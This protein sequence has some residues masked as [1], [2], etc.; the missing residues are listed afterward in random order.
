MMSSR[1]LVSGRPRGR[2][3]T[4]LN[5]S[6]RVQKADRGPGL[7]MLA[8]LLLWLP[9]RSTP[10]VMRLG[11]VAAVHHKMRHFPLP[12]PHTHMHKTHTRT[13]HHPF[14]TTRR[15]TSHPTGSGGICTF[16]GTKVALT[17]RGGP[18]PLLA[19]PEPEAPAPPAPAAAAAGTADG[20]GGGGGGGGA[21]AAV[22]DEVHAAA[23]A[24]K[25][26]LVDYDR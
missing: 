6:K 19:A 22:V 1:S 14:S 3:R 9:A 13:K 25:D 16:C 21:A 15:P 26:R 18:P 11:R 7:E 4:D 24:F 5:G 17:Y 8:V 23:V 2:F 10:S 20:G 12:P